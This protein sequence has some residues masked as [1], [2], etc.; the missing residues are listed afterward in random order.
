[1][2]RKR[3]LAIVVAGVLLLAGVTLSLSMNNLDGLKSD[4]FWS[5]NRGSFVCT[6]QAVLPGSRETKQYTANLV[7][8]QRLQTRRGVLQSDT[9]VVNNTCKD[10]KGRERYQ[11]QF[12]I[13]ELRTIENRLDKLNKVINAYQNCK[14]EQ[15]P[16][17]TVVVD[18]KVVNVTNN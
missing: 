13:V 12:D 14:I 7:E 17:P 1:M 18:D 16:R 10:L 4:I 5:G 3:K 15:Y 2:I 9:N 6:P 11:C 8:L